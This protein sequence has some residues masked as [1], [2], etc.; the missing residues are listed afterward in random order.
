[1][2]Q[3]SSH[4]VT[5]LIAFLVLTNFFLVW[6]SWRHD[7]DSD[8]DP[9]HVNTKE[10]NCPDPMVLQNISVEHSD[11]GHDRDDHGIH[12]MPLFQNESQ[13]HIV[14]ESQN[15]TGVLLKKSVDYIHRTRKPLPDGPACSVPIGF[16]GGPPRTS[17]LNNLCR[18]IPQ[19]VR[20]DTSKNCDQCIPPLGS[21]VPKGCN[22]LTR[23]FQERE[24]SSREIRRI[25]LK[26]LVS[27][28]L[29]FPYDNS[30]VVII[31]LNYGYGY[32]F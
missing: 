2:T 5:A 6:R 16:P 1:M 12:L 20:C 11:N 28:N 7:R 9:V 25:E 10:C 27:T 21:S 3:L 22:D 19:V 18:N 23:I 8:T 31:T 4:F 29:S 30:H 26:N 15:R 32:V 14:K 17:N 13:K 24:S